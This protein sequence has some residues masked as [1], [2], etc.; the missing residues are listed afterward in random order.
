MP[1]IMMRCTGIILL[2]LFSLTARADVLYPWPGETEVQLQKD[3][4]KGAIKGALRITNPGDTPWLIQTW[5]ED[6]QY[7]RHH[8]VYPSVL[9]LEPFS[10][11]MLNIYPD[12]GAVAGHLKWLLINIV[13]STAKEKRNQLVIPVT[14]RLK[15]RQQEMNRGDGADEP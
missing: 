4:E 12:K 3:G 6:E 9:R 11:R 10:A 2:M 15:I 8:I 5:V 14:Y 1:V 7:G 13:P